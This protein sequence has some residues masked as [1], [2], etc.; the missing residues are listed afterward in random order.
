[1]RIAY[2]QQKV[3]RGAEFCCVSYSH[4]LLFGVHSTQVNCSSTVPFNVKLTLAQDASRG[5]FEQMPLN[6]IAA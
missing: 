2:M 3:A 1:M 6:P 4:W 5:P